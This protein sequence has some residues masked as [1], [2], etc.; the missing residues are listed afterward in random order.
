MKIKYDGTGA[1]YGLPEVFCDCRICRHA[2]EAGG[3]NIRTRSQAVLDGQLAIDLSVDTF[4][5]SAFCG[6]DMRKIH[7]VLVTHNH[8]DH[9]FTTDLF[10]RVKN[11]TEPVHFYISEAS[12][13]GVRALVEKYE[14]EI[15]A[16]KRD[17]QAWTR[18]VVHTL[19]YFK[20]VKIL[21]YTVTP[22]PARHGK[23]LDPMIFVIQSEAGNILWGHDTGKFFPETAQWLKDSGIVFDFVSLDCTLR[24]GA[25]IT[26]SHMDL[27]W[28]IEMADLLRENGNA[29]ENTKFVLSHIGHLVD[30]THDELTC[31]AAEVGMIVAYDG[32]E[33]EFG[34]RKGDR[35]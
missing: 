26:P 23:G 29:N 6:L 20:P 12:G 31:E 4:H 28:C 21:D 2:R 35:L 11:M 16:G 8:H 14:A 18:A 27:D 19:E 22:L 30:R 33:M 34:K 7:H 17:P 9:F 3:K 25:Q 32:M 1:G 5:H 24:R 15:A 10:S 13:Q